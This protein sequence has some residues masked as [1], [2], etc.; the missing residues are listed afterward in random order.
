[1]YISSRR[2]PSGRTGCGRGSNQAAIARREIEG[3][4]ADELS[5]LNVRRLVLEGDPARQIVEFAHRE[6]TDIIAMPT[7][8]YGPFRRF[9]L[10][11]NTAKVLHDADCAV[12]TGVHLGASAGMASNAVR[13]RAVRRGPGSAKFQ[14]ARLGGPGWR[15][16]SARG[17]GVVH[18]TAAVPDLGDDPEVAVED[19]DPRRGRAGVVPSAGRFVGAEADLSIEAGRPGR[20]DLFRG[21]ARGGRRGGNRPR[22]GRGRLRPP[23]H[24]RLRDHPAVALPGGQRLV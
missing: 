6:H 18:A 2:R 21:R 5:G 22:I 8:G 3:F 24:Q 16:S 20:R 15:G 23:A 10:G 17:S 11:S 7:H 12:W 9:I 1:M 19:G 13:Q 14:D 4:L